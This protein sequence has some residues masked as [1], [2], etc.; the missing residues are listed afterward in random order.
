MLHLP[1][2]HYMNRPNARLLKPGDKLYHQH[3]NH[4]ANSPKTLVTFRKYCNTGIGVEELVGSIY[5]G[6]FWLDID[7][8]SGNILIPTPYPKNPHLSR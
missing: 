7:E 8:S 2:T 1:L 6:S 5:S 3:V 4:P